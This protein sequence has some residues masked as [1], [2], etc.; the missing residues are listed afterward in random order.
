MMSA[1]NC[2][3]EVQSSVCV[4]GIPSLY[5]VALPCTLCLFPFHFPS[6]HGGEKE[7]EYSGEDDRE[8]E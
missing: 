1:F 7:E 2:H 4:A 8:L 5:P 3:F 6:S